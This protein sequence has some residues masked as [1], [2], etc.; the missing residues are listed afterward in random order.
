MNEGVTL[1]F[2]RHGETDWNLTRRIQGQ[3]DTELNETG[4]T[5]AARNALRLRELN[6]DI[7]AMDYLSSPLTRCRQTMDIVRQVLDLPPGDYWVDDRLMEIHFGHWQGAYWPEV[8]AAD[9]V[10]VMAR[11]RDPFNWRPA[12]GESYADLSHRVADWLAGIERDTIVVSHGGVSRALRGVVFALDP[13][14]ITELKVPQDRVLVINK[15]EMH[16]I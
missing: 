9:P 16:W 3:I 7:W 15:H 5:Q 14:E 12:D 13:V 6:L 8:P 10:G 4:R 11:E 1:Y 2:C